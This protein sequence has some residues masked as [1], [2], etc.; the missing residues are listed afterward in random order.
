MGRSPPKTPSGPTPTDGTVRALQ[1]A[2]VEMLSL[3][4]RLPN[5]SHWLA[6]PPAMMVLV[7]TCA[8]FPNQTPAAVGALLETTEA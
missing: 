5:P 8:P 3:L 4:C 1:S 6:S 2:S 7:S